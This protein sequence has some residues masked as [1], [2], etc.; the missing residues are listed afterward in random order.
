MTSNKRNYNHFCAHSPDSDD[1]GPNCKHQRME[2][3]GTNLDQP[4]MPSQAQTMT[5]N[6]D[7]TLSTPIGNSYPATSPNAISNT[8][9]DDAR[10]LHAVEQSE[11]FVFYKS[12]ATDSLVSVQVKKPNNTRWT[13]IQQFWPEITTCKRHCCAN[14]PRGRAYACLATNGMQHRRTAFVLKTSMIFNRFSHLLPQMRHLLQLP[15]L[16]Y[17]ERLSFDV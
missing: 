2:S 14:R 5:L 6:R 16:Q 8:R 4:N 7:A 9:Q 11:A 3:L 10:L 13:T 15:E 17:G 12:K 1:F